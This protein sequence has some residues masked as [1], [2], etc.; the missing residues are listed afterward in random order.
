VK[1]PQEIST[2]KDRLLSSKPIVVLVALLLALV[3]ASSTAFASSSTGTSYSI[4][5]ATATPQFQCTEPCVVP[6]LIGYS[7]TGQ[8]TCQTGCAG[9]P[10]DPVDATLTFS[11]TRTFPPNPCLM[12]RGTG[13]LDVT[14]PSDPL[15]P[16]AVGTFTFKARD[17]KT[18]DFAGSITSSTLSVLLPNEP[19]E[20]FVTFPPNPCL[21]GTA[22]AAFTFG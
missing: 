17:S 21:G 11:V 4:A 2:M 13:T 18:V 9:F 15:L 1:H 19:I 6:T 22:T 14:W 16:E 10:S 12:Q 7:Y 3:I 8:G 20:G 5:A